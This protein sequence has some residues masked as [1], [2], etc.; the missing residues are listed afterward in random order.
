MGVS[1]P[2]WR[3]EELEVED[4]MGAGMGVEV[5]DSTSLSARTFRVREIRRLGE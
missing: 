2:C 3:E 4:W 1:E 5:L